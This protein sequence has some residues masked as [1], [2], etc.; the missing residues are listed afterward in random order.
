MSTFRRRDGFPGERM[1]KIPESAVRQILDN[2]PMLRQLYIREIGYFPKALFHYRE[3]RTGCADNILFYCIQGK[4]WYVVD[5]K[6]YAVNANEYVI[7]P[8]T[9][10]YLRYW[11]DEEQP[12]TIYWVHFTG[13]NMDAFNKNMH[14]SLHAGP[15]PIPFSETS[16]AQWTIIF[17]S[18]KM[19]LSTENICNANFYLYALLATF[20]FPQHHMAKQ[21]PSYN[22][23]VESSISFMQKNLDKRLSVL[24]IATVNKISASYLSNL[25]RSSTGIA[26]IDYFI[27]LKIQRACKLLQNQRIKVKD[28]AHAVGYDDPYYFS[29]IFKKLMN[30]SPES[31]R[32]R[33]SV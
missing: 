25:F 11:A 24:D 9:K 10:K 14:I 32:E 7:I 1:I 4:G 17:E 19:G 22:I 6:K 23:I 27:Q 3:R 13:G 12:W 18:L 15:S 30:I 20:L 29:R 8:A 28:V 33:N 2:N 31:Y 16:I 21:D 26:P 5:D